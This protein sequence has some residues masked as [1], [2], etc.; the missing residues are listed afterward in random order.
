MAKTRLG[1]LQRKLEEMQKEVREWRN[2]EMSSWIGK[3]GRSVRI[4]TLEKE[5]DKTYDL[6]AEELSIQKGLKKPTNNK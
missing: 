2:R 1:E 3:W 4:K 6:I 5:I